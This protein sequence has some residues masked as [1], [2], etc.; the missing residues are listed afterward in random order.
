MPNK[1]TAQVHCT[2]RAC[3]FDARAWHKQDVSMG[4]TGGAGANS[5]S[6]MMPKVGISSYILLKT[7]HGDKQAPTL[8]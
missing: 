3:D 2:L 6:K 7:V 5:V 4:R 1:G 8:K